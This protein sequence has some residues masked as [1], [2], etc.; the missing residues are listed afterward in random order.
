[1]EG[2]ENNSWIP[3][4]PELLGFDIV[5][6]Q[7]VD[8]IQTSPTEIDT[9]PLCIHEYTVPKRP[10][11]TSCDHNA[12]KTNC[13]ICNPHRYCQHGR[14]KY[15]CFDCGGFG[16]CKHKQKRSLCVD[17]GGAS[18]CEHKKHKSACRICSPH[19]FCEH[20][21]R[22]HSCQRCSP[23]IY[24]PHDVRRYECDIC[25]QKYAL[26]KRKVSVQKK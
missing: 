18:I 9:T 26:V 8:S 6:T 7:E 19:L 4:P 3:P 21:V 20:R 1:M 25:K 13:R 24:C 5:G 12:R 23:Y 11:K 16:M 2:I 14:T 22:R 15:Y 10:T 17:C